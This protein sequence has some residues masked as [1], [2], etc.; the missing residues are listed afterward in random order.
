MYTSTTFVIVS[1]ERF[2]TCS[3]ICARVTFCPALRIRYSSSA[4]SFGVS[5][6]ARARAL[7]RC[8][9]RFNS[10]S[11]MRNTVFRP[12]SAPPQKRPHPR[13]KLGK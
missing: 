10:R 7:H 3:M 6:T 12:A 9:T 2:H 8:S 13:R 1:N 4:N 5:S 11:S